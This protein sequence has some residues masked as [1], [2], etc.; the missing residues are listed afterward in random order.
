VVN[1]VHKLP[2]IEIMNDCLIEFKVRINKEI[3]KQRNK[4][5]P[6]NELINYGKFIPLYHEV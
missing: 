2:Y 6:E 3:K 1:V 5:I 4:E